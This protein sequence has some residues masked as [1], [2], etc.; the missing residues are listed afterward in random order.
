MKVQVFRI[1][2]L[3]KLYQQDVQIL[4]NFLA[5][6]KLS[7]LQTAFI[8]AEPNYWS[9]LIFYSAINTKSTKFSVN[10][11]D[12]LNKKEKEIYEY[13]KAWR[14]DKAEQLNIPPFMICHNTELMSIAKAKPKSAEE[15]IQIKGFGKYKTEK[16]G[17][18]II[19]LLH[20]V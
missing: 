20:T 14:R 2:M 19:V 6:H 8:E 1:R 5:T 16:Y 9:I 12:G 18:D 4:N 10:T 7:R 13:L 17:E 3:E 11:I 15:L